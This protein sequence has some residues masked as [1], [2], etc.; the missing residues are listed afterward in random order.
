[1]AYPNLEAFIFFYL[2]NYPLGEVLEFFRF[3]DV[4][5]FVELLFY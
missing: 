3:S 4:Q 5:V 2:R 1:M